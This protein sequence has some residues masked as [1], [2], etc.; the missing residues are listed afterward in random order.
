MMD[1]VDLIALSLRADAMRMTHD[2]VWA[3]V[4]PFYPLPLPDADGFQ[5]PGEITEVV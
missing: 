2:G 1:Y 3:S 4:D 5:A